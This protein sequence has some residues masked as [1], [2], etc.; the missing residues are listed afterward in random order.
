MNVIQ[1][2]RVY[3]LSVLTYSD[4][5]MHPAEEAAGARTLV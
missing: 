5:Q 2:E 4:M 1:F 3:D